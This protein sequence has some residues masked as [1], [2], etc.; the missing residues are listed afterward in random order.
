MKIEIHERIRPF[1]RTPGTWLPIPGSFWA[2]S[3]YPAEIRMR[4]WISGETFIL[5]VQISGPVTQFIATSD[6]ERGGISVSF[7]EVNGWFRYWLFDRNGLKLYQEK[8]HAIQDGVSSPIEMVD[9]MPVKEERALE[10]LFLGSTKKQEIEAVKRRGL[11]E[12]I[13]PFWFQFGY[14]LPYSGP[15]VCLHTPSSLLENFE[16]GFS[17][18][19]I[20]EPSQFKLF[21]IKEPLSDN[22]IEQLAG[23]ARAIRSIFVKETDNAVEIL[24]G[25]FPQL[26][27]GKFTGIQLRLG[28]LSIEW[29]KGKLRRASFHGTSNGNFM[30]HFPEGKSCTLDITAGTDYFFDRFP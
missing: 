29:T 17:G 16:A 6:W 8:G 19:L 11:L 7:K 10:R 15:E 23:I 1:S 25:L 5:P 9:S 20:P 30:F 3:I 21:G 22:P 24:P 27:S 14:I 18:F 26:K 28:T 4:S 13:L 2:A 12:E